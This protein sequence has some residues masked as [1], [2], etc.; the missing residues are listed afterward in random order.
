MKSGTIFL[1][2]MLLCA[3]ILINLSG[4]WNARELNALSIVVGI[5]IDK[6][7]TPG[8]V[9]LTAQIVK[10]S[11]MKKPSKDGGGA[12]AKAYWD[13]TSSSDTVFDAV[14]KFT[15]ETSNKL[16]IAHNQVIILGRDIAVEGVQKYLD[17]FMRASE[18]R[19]TTTILVSSGKASEVLKVKP[20]LDKLP[21]INIA[22]L[23][24][25]QDFTS[26]SKRVILQDF[27]NSLLS[28]TT[29]SI[30]PIITVTGEGSQKSLHIKGLAVFKG[31]KM[32][33]E[34]NESE[35]RGLLWV[36]GE[37]KTGVIDVPFHNGK[38]S[39]EI[40]RAKSKITPIIMNGEIYMYVK[41][42][43]EG[44]IVAQ[45]NPE[46]LTTVATF[47]QLEKLQ[48]DLIRDEIVSSLEKAKYLNT[49]IFGF[50]EEIH[51]KY[52]NQWK[53][54]EKNWEEIFPSIQVEIEIDSKIR[55][56]GLISKPAVPE[57]KE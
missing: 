21:A 23:A 2:K 50:G 55:S 25:A 6:A 16:Y 37:V 57:K 3:F 28:R 36:K 46:N 20:E 35:A 54:L 4:C 32:A 52:R 49:D 19:P 24:K 18:T 5:G 27:I 15:H 8:N 10:P 1:F 42:K 40:K 48:N 47:A 26:Q 34:L 53:Q 9:L 31:D 43:E 39:L 41:I 29:S 45:T 44:V 17:F 14:R 7:E 51:K 56:A 38:V 22:K 12:E 33:G 13:I 30:A 11:E